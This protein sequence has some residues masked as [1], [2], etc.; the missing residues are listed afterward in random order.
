MIATI[1]LIFNFKQ[2]R[3]KKMKTKNHTGENVKGFKQHEHE[4]QGKVLGK[5]NPNVL[6]ID[7]DYYEEKQEMK[8]ENKK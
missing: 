7:R 2:T 8:N 1:K 6:G 4:E 3:G 5:R